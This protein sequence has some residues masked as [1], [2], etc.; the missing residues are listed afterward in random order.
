MLK[1]PAR[2]RP[3]GTTFG[4]RR[5]RDIAASYR[6]SITCS[7]KF[8]RVPVDIHVPWKCRTVFSPGSAFLF[9]AAFTFH[10]DT[11]NHKSSELWPFE[12][13]SSR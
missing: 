3:K 13:S 9:L 12:S 2:N 11:D 8:S 5:I 7:A 4:M 1:Q 6:E 10:A